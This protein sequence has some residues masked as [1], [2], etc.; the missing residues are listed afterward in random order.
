MGM[1]QKSLLA[2]VLSPSQVLQFLNCPAKWMFRY[3]RELKEPG[4]AEKALGKAFHETVARNFRQKIDT[5]RDLPLA[6]CLE[7]FREALG[8]HLQELLPRRG[9][10]PTEML[11]VGGV[12]VAKYLEEAA[13]S[14]QPA[15][16][17]SKVSGAI[18]GVKVSGYVDLLD[19]LGRIIDSKT[20]V[21]PFRGIAHDHRLQLATYSI[22]T[23]AS[24][25]A[26]RVDT[27]TKGKTVR[28]IQ[29]SFMVSEADRRYLE[30]VYPM[31][32]ASVRN[33]VFLP[34]RNSALCSRTFCG[35][36]RVCEREFGG[37]VR[38]GAGFF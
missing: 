8:R 14:I 11:D 23:A 17:E 37:S 27:V 3:L 6:E 15:A 12:M 35:F 33:G 19:V 1:E 4:T 36:W 31:V 13:P 2:E 7:F 26:C 10:H 21:K 38:D 25:G 18:G 5:A 34:R 22:I 32:Q 9:E 16:V 30:K 29:K 20:A 28:V 24:S